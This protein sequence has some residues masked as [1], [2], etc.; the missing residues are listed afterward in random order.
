MTRTPRSGPVAAPTSGEGRASR[1]PRV[2]A[3]IGID[4]AGKTTQ[5]RWLAAWLTGN[6]TR[7]TY[8]L[9]ASGRRWFGRLAQRLGRRDAEDL[10]GHRGV[11]LT[12]MLL[13]WLAIAR[14]LL[15]GRLHGSVA[16]MDR[17]AYCQ[18]AAISVRGGRYE[19]LARRLFGIF[20]PPDRTFLLAV[21]PAEAL[22]RIERRATDTEDPRY[23]ARL[24]EAYR[25]LPEAAGFEII[26]ASQSLEAV[27]K[28]LRDHLADW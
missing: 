24:D 3:L 7:A 21:P 19:R 22:T 11:V 8:H 23:L 1:R 10:L 14:A 16:V 13:R 20:P 6:G 17:Y 4:G 12:E 15:L 27:Q 2:V 25:T 28:Q 9:N 26:D 5:A 18:Y